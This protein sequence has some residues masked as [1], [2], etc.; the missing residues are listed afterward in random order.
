[1]IDYK[2]KCTYN[3][4]AK[5][6]IKFEITKEDYIKF[7]LYHIE[8]SPTQKKTFNILRYGI[9]ILF[10]LIIYFIG[11]NLFKQPSI[12]WIII[13]ILFTVIWIATYPMQYRALIRKETEKMVDEGDN[14]EIFGN[15]TMVIDDEG[16][17]IYNKSSSEKI[18]KEAIKSVK[19]YDDMIL[20]YISSINAYIVPNRYLD[21][22][23]KDKFLQ[24]LNSNLYSL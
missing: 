16:I 15:K 23:T 20:I 21:E 18:L 14:S 11:T 13:A 4:G 24:Y 12:Y 2:N 10:S 5:V 9:P 7:N 3:G 19:N 22:A 6:E 8:N 17:T 1:M